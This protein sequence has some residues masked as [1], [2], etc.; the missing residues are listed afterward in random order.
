MG[1]ALEL[2]RHENDVF[3]HQKRNSL[4]TLSRVDKYENALV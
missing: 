2:L 3:E 4:K 1:E